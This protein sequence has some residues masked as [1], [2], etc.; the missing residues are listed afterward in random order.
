MTATPEQL[1]RDYL[2]RLER[3][4][5]DLPSARRREIVGD[6][7]EHIAE[8]RAWGASDEGSV[9]S[10]LDRL[11]DPADI[12]AEARERFGVRPRRSGILEIAALV[13]LLVGGV[14]LPVV[15]WFIGVALLWASAVWTTREKLVG[16][17][18]VPGGLAL[19]LFLA[20][21]PAYSSECSGEVD[22]ET[23]AAIPGTEAC[24]GGPPEALE[25]LGP[26]LFVILLIAP[27]VTTIYLARSL[28]REA[29]AVAY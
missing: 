3:E 12:A 16:T 9:R 5:S 7:S 22:P 11:G 26:I 27:L 20:V 8:A 25:V 4:L 18:V 1:V 29:R 24:T 15:G 10:L 21:F 17:L 6:I 14:L 28:R 13:L 23:G 2:D 19:P